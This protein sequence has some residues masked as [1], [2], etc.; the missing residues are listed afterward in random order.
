MMIGV[1][2]HVLSWG[3][4]LVL[5]TSSL[6]CALEVPLGGAAERSREPGV[7]FMD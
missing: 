1:I 6:G 3:N 4:V 2:I 7:L 5:A